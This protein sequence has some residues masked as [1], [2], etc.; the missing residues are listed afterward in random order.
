MI[1]TG[2]KLIVIDT[3]NGP[4]AK[5]NSK[6]ANGLFAANMVAAGF[7]PKAVDMVVISHFHGDHVN[8]LLDRGRHA[9]ISE[10]RSAGARRRMEVS[11]WMTAR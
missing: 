9:G 7:D 8:G 4:V 1:N 5:A 2:G 6:G 11:S 10:R 3:G